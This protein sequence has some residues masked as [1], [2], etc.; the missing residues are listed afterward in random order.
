MVELYNSGLTATQVA[1][2]VGCSVS[3]AKHALVT[4]GVY[5]MYEKRIDWPIEE[6]RKWY[7][8]D[9]MT[10][11]EIGTKLGQNSKVV[12]KVCKRNGFRMR[13]RGQKFGDQHKGWKGG[14]TTDK[15]GYI[16]VYCPDHPNCNNSGYVREHRLVM[17]QKLGRLLERHE[18]VHHIDGVKGNNDPNNLGL[19][20]SN[21]RH[22]AE[23]L[24]GKCPN[25]TPEGK[26]RLLEATR[27]VGRRSS[28]H[29]K[30]AR[31]AVQSP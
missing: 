6:M 25:W 12:N 2:A 7:E 4:R 22:L 13:P 9:G 27:R 20:D 11:A 16:L 10:V 5:R 1:K 8:I 30:Q 31:D 17:E 24:A 14:K 19:F 3:N 18:V 15:S 26:Q 23:T 21:G 29:K 28:S